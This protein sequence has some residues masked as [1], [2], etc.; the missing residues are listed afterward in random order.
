MKSNFK[1]VLSD[2]I[3]DVREGIC[4]KLEREVMR[5]E[6]IIQDLKVNFAEKL[7]E[8]IHKELNVV[9]GNFENKETQIE[10]YGLLIATLS[11]I[12]IDDIEE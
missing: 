2:T 11:K 3:Y 6:D 7:L 5:F 8:D 1:K 10:R 9:I 4:K 12:S